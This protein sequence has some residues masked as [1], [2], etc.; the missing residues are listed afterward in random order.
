MKRGVLEIQMTLLEHIAAAS[1]A[2]VP[3]PAT[4][5]NNV[6]GYEFLDFYS[7]EVII[8]AI[9]GLCQAMI[10]HYSL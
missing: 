4:L 10:Q 3:S 1:S 5:A 8:D 7:S 6:L 2:V 9:L